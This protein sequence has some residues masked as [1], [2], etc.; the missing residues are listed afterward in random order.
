MAMA[1]V[2]CNELGGTALTFE[3]AE[4]LGSLKELYS[5]ADCHATMQTQICMFLTP[6]E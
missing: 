6:K 3:C 2:K 1:C 4:C 5:S